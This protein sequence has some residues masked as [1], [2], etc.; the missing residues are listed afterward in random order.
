MSVGALG[1]EKDLN[2]RHAAAVMLSRCRPFAF[3]TSTYFMKT[4]ARAYMRVWLSSSKKKQYV[5]G[6]GIKSSV[7]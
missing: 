5:S 7:L 1:S 2:Y 6:I 3:S 4:T